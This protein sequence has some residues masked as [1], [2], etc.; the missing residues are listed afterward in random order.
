MRCVSCVAGAQRT[1]GSRLVAAQRMACRAAYLCRVPGC[2]PCRGSRSMALREASR[3]RDSK[4][5]WS[6]CSARAGAR[7]IARSYKGFQR[8]TC[9]P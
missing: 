8:I 4:R 6:G 1:D 2:L 5:W 9:E 3:P 7:H